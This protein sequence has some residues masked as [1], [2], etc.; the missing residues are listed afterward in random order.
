[1]AGN[2]NGGGSGGD[3][4]LIIFVVLIIA[5]PLLA[6]FFL[7]KP[8]VFLW[9]WISYGQIWLLAHYKA[10]TGGHTVAIELAANAPMLHWLLWGHA[11]PGKISWKDVAAVSSS[12]GAY[13]RWIVIPII[14]A[15]A[16][17]NF[18]AVEKRKAR[19]SLN[20]TV[21][22]M[23]DRFPWGLPWLWQQSEILCRTGS[24]PFRYALR[25]WEWIHALQGD[26][27]RPLVC[28]EREDSP[29]TIE[30]LDPDKIRDAL[31]K[32]LAHPTDA[33]AKWPVWFQALTTACIPQARDS[34]DRDTY[35]RLAQLA[36]HY[37]RVRPKKGQDYVPPEL[38]TVPWP[39]TDADQDYLAQLGKRH[40]FRETLFMGLLA[41]ARV[42]GLLPPAYFAWLRA[43]DRNLWYAAQ[44]LGRPRDFI[45]G[46]GVL[47]HY[48]AE[49]GNANKPA[50]TDQESIEYLYGDRGLAL[51][52]PQVE[53]AVAGL[54]F[55][56]R[57]EDAGIARDE[58]SGISDIP[59]E[60]RS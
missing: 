1:M 36:R 28:K 51:T 54:V 33:Y 57:E 10:W 4:G 5:G 53:S 7:Q 35:K 9:S 13:F 60:W 38:K 44:S 3:S 48:Q 45:E 8:V 49:R 55:A 41:E 11:H 25:P 30:L 22:A 39:V 56:L 50:P 42:R 19:Q 6:W 52:T 32:Q 26:A 12:L 37:Y 29:E 2:S 46:H 58:I 34:K 47:A 16:W 14:A 43:L 18:R 23:Q 59:A 40:G 17:L 20:D 31:Q 24:G 27:K 21:I 15:L